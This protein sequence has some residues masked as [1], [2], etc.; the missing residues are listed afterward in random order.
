[1]PSPIPM[2]TPMRVPAACARCAGVLALLLSAAL[3]A[4]SG[5]V[6]SE[7]MQGPPDDGD[8][9]GADGGTDGGSGALDGGVDSGPEGPDAGNDGGSD[10]GIDAG[11]DA[12]PDAGLD[13]GPDGGS[14]AGSGDGGVAVGS[15]WRA[16]T[17]VNLRTGPATTYGVVLVIPATGLSQALSADVSGGFLHLSYAGREGYSSARY[18][19]PAPV[20]SSADLGSTFVARAKAAVGFS[21]WWGHGTWSTDPAADKGSCSG[22]CPSCTHAGP[23]G[24]DCSGMVAKAWLVPPSNWSFGA[25]AHPYST[26]NFYN[27]TTWWAPIDRASAA[28]GDAMVYRI[29]GSGHVFLYESGDPWGSLVA[30]ECKGCAAGCVR[31]TRTASTDYKAIRRS[32][33]VP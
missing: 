3:S 20:G 10:A 8:P 33:N 5:P 12:G 23:S 24:A 4:C 21:Y 31:D 30:V 32:A 22:N 1:M 14:D 7:P 29:G 25:D 9:P 16:T 2:P 6:P 13:A 15:V 19:E 11:P 17:D 18:Q 27:D 26:D 28:R